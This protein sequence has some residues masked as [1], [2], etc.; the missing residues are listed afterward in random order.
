MHTLLQAH[1]RLQ[2]RNGDTPLHYCAAV[3]NDEENFIMYSIACLLDGGADANV[4]N[5][6]GR[7]PL[8]LASRH[9][10]CK[11]MRQLLDNRMS[12]AYVDVR[13]E[14]DDTPLFYASGHVDAIRLLINF[15]ADVNAR[16]RY[17][18]TP[19]IMAVSATPVDEAFAVVQLL[20]NA[21]ADP[22]V[23]DA[24][25]MTALHMACELGRDTIA[26]LL[27]ERG[28]DVNANGGDAATP[29]HR[30]AEY[31]FVECMQLLLECGADPHAKD[32]GD[33]KTALH[34]AVRCE[35]RRS[36]TTQ[37]LI[38]AGA[39]ASAVDNEGA[40]P[41]HELLRAHALQEI[42]GDEE[43]DADSDE[44]NSMVINLIRLLTDNG[45]DV[46][47]LD[48][49]GHT[50]LFTMYAAMM[51][52]DYPAHSDD[53]D[54]NLFG[55]YVEKV[56]VDTYLNSLH[57]FISFYLFSKCIELFL[58]IAHLVTPVI[59]RASLVCISDYSKLLSIDESPN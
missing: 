20:L 22:K 16:S 13:D 50:P 57:N 41:M 49:N 55:H 30:A 23:L 9:N 12:R 47:A 42:A 26:K 37:L 25:G 29:L 38:K 51:C 58:L 34:Y 48:K 6:W 59:I 45:A 7:T 8:H 44:S 14:L 10:N 3:G 31:G 11:I 19:L 40:T 15:G 17:D 53:V 35:R 52:R 54:E 32:P 5:E 43:D 46:N 27:L 2:D 1:T 24:S 21:G 18:V 33:G 36:I 28:S 56:R 4:R 39:D